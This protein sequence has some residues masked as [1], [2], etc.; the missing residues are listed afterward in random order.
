MNALVRSS[1]AHAFQC[2]VC[3]RA[4]A[5]TWSHA[6]AGALACAKAVAQDNSSKIP[7]LRTA[8]RRT[9]APGMSGSDRDQGDVFRSGF[10]RKTL[11][12]TPAQAR[13]LDHRPELLLVKAI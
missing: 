9:R 5:T 13:L 11:R 8:A 1:P 3:P 7:A 2:T 4:F 6:A 12:G 10:G